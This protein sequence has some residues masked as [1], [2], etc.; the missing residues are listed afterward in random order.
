M[1][2]QVSAQVKEIK[3]VANILEALVQECAEV[4]QGLK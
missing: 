1:A 2:G 3:P 4:I